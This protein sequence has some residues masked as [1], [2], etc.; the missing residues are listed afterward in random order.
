MTAILLE[1]REPAQKLVEQVAREVEALRHQ[2]RRVPRLACVFAAGDSAALAYAKQQKRACTKAGIE[3]EPIELPE[4]STQDG[5]LETIARLNARTDLTGVILQVPL[6]APFDARAAQRAI[7]AAKDVEGILPASLGA[8]VHGDTSLPPCTA[9]AAVE[10]LRTVRPSV[11]GLEITVVGHS[12]I[13]GKPLALILLGSE[14]EAA[15]PTVC[16]IAT[17][18]L[19]VHTRRAEVLFVAAGKPGLIR[20]DMVKTGAIVIDIG[21][22]VIEGKEPDGSPARRLVGDVD[23]ESVRPVAGYVTPVPGGVGP[24][25]AAVLMRNAAECAR[26]IF[27]A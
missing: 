21:F 4:G 16:H 7:A 23:F 1:G 6:P 3:Y 18:D 8:L 20:G 17:R 25:T 22:N 5:L 24:M 13:V 2:F 14:R 26:R 11:K 27:G 12:E 15:T 9:M 19:A 10:L